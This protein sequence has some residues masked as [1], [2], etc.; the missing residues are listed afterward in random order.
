MKQ[1]F[2]SSSILEFAQ[3]TRIAGNGESD[4]DEIPFSAVFVPLT[5]RQLLTQSAREQIWIRFRIRNPGMAGRV[6]LEY[7]DPRVDHIHVYHRMQDHSLSHRGG[8]HHPETSLLL[9]PSFPLMLPANSESDVYIR[10]S[11]AFDVSTDLTLYSSRSFIR[12]TQNL[13]LLHSIFMALLAVLFASQLL[14][15]SAQRNATLGGFLIYLVGLGVYLSYRSGFYQT[16]LS[17]DPVFFQ[18]LPAP[19]FGLM[20]FGGILFMRN[21]LNVVAR[22]PRL[23]RVLKACQY[24]ALL[25][26]P[27]SL[28]SLEWTFAVGS[29][30]SLVVPPGL[31]LIA[32]LLFGSSRAGR[33]FSALWAAPIVTVLLDGLT[34]GGAFTLPVD[35]DVLF[36]SGFLIQIVGFASFL[37]FRIRKEERNRL[38]QKARLELIEG[39][40]ER[41]R[42]ILE[43]HRPGSLDF[44]PLNVFV[45]YEPMSHLGGDYY[46]VVRHSDGGVGILVADVTGHGLPAAL[47]ASTVHVAHRSTYA[48]TTHAGGV[49]AGMNAFLA[50]L[51][52]YRFVSAIYAIVYPETGLVRISR[53]GHPP[54]ILISRDGRV[55]SLGQE[56]PLL[57]LVPGFSYEE[58]EY[59]MRSGDRLLMFTDGIY[60]VPDED[61][62]PELPGIQEAVARNVACEGEDL[63][64]AISKIYIPYRPQDLRDDETFL[65]IRMK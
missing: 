10:L 37:G 62:I 6:Y 17:A 36:H 9:R 49:L 19:F 38:E 11:N 54:A 1:G 39:D 30:M 43:S 58:R 34:K 45:H 50:P 63:V 24:L 59:E 32:L 29:R 42:E 64:Q 27:L 16:Y 3:Y 22:F 46:S 61:S 26:F 52:S 7:R 2:D 28:I 31:F 53:A 4:G 65:E 41:A 60:E 14:L 8:D 57:G 40:L 21:F 23:D 47:D 51:K 55:E 18:Q 15:Y 12:H 33:T 25:V 56:A 20:Y 48:R 44:P 5:A 35:P 13:T